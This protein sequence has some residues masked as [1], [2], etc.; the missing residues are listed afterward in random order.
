MEVGA[1]VA[2]IAN[3]RNERE[4]CVSIER[5]D[6]GSTAS[7]SEG[8]CFEEQKMKVVSVNVGLPREVPW[9]GGRVMTGIF[10]EPI[11]DSVAVRRLNLD[12]DRQADLTVHGG[13][14]KAV[15][16]YPAEHYPKWRTEMPEL[17]FPLGAFGENL[18]VEGMDEGTL[19]I[20]D[21][22]RVGTAVL[23]VT[24]PRMPCYKLGIR[25]QRDDMIKRFLASGRSGFYFSVEEEGEVSAGSEIEV[26]SRDPH[27]VR[28]A[29]IQLLYLHQNKDATLLDRAVKVEALP[30]SWR[31]WLIEKA[32]ARATRA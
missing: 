5:I 25:F 14:Y 2:R 10:K 27:K 32:R 12:G 23:V 19:H 9:N 28:V 15:Y 17:E 7:D 1:I 24:Q 3:Q 22:I 26:L 13:E 29:D 30:D 31:K 21:R 20:G 4:V 18:T 11:S 6:S 8:R 16:A